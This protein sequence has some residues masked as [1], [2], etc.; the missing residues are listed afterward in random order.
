[1]HKVNIDEM[2]P[3]AVTTPGAEKVAIQWLV[4]EANGAAPNFAMRRFIIEPGGNTPYHTHDWEHLVYTLGGTGVAQTEDGPVA[5]RAGD[6]MMI[7]PNAEHS[8]ENTGDGPLEFLC[9]VPN[10]PATQGH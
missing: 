7:A 6:A 5:I 4:S 3:A 10:G 8:F 1:M 9:L 2:E